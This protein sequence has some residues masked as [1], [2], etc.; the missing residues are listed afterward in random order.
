MCCEVMAN[1]PREIGFRVSVKRVFYVTIFKKNTALSSL[2][3]YGSLRQ[4]R[5]PLS[6]SDCLQNAYHLIHDHSTV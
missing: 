4:L 5:F 3:R 2:H 6:L 1:S